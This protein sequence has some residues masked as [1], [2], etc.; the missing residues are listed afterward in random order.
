MLESILRSTESQRLGRYALTPAGDNALLKDLCEDFKDAVQRVPIISTY[1]SKATKVHRNVFAKFARKSS[2]MKIITPETCAIK[3]Q[4]ERPVEESDGDHHDICKLVVNGRLYTSIRDSISRIIDSTTKILEQEESPTPPPG[5]EGMTLRSQ[6]SSAAANDSQRIPIVIDRVPSNQNSST[7]PDSGDAVAGST[8]QASYEVVEVDLPVSFDPVKRSP[9]LPCFSVTS[10]EQNTAFFGREAVLRQIDKFLRPKATR[11]PEDLV[12]EANLLSAPEATLKTFALCGIG[13][14]GKTRIALQYAHTRRSEFEAIFWVSA[15]NSNVLA[16]EFAQIA[17]ELGLLELSEAQDLPAACE[18]V[19][20][21]LCNPVRSYD[22]GAVA[23]REVP[24]LL[25]FDNVDELDVLS[26]FWPTAGVGS[27]LMT[28]RDRGAKSHT[29][30]ANNGIDL[31]PFSGTEAEGFM[32]LITPSQS[33]TGQDAYIAEVAS[34]LGGLPLLITQ[35]S[36]LMNRLFLS[37]KDFLQLCDE[38]GISQVDW[39]Q[40]DSS[41]AGLV[42]SIFQKLGLGGLPSASLSILQM[43][44]FL[45][46][47]RVPEDILKSGISIQSVAGF[48]RTMKDY[49]DARLKLMQSSLIE[50]QP[51]T[52]HKPE[53]I[54]LHR[55]IQDV[56]RDNLGPSERVEIFE[57]TVKAVS[58]VWPFGELVD[59]FSTDR[60]EKCAGIFPSVIRLKGWQ[61]QIHQISYCQDPDSCAALYNDAGWYWFERGFPEEA[62]EYFRMTEKV[63]KKYQE[64]NATQTDK[65]IY[66]L[67]RAN[68]NHATASMETNDPKDCLS[69]YERWLSESSESSPGLDD[70]AF[71][72]ELACIH[73]ELGVAY[74]MNEQFDT[75]IACFEKSIQSFQQL[76]NY[77]DTMLNWPEPN[78]GFMYWVQGRYE[79]AEDVLLEI[80]SIHEE[81][82]GPDDTT[83]FKTGKMLYALGNVYTDRGLKEPDDLKR[84]EWLD[85]GLSFHSRCLKQYRTTLG[86]NHHRVGDVLHRLAD[87]KIRSKHFKEAHTFIKQAMDIFASR[88]YYKNELA[89]TTYKKGQMLLAEG[90]IPAAEKEFEKA[91]KLR[92]SLRPKDVKEKEDL[93]ELDYNSLVIFWSR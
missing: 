68:L 53:A 89:R 23:D 77:E 5:L 19:K 18:V 46:P 54:S 70:I 83:S 35:M 58:A 92:K 7:L 43:V 93:S 66:L 65:M 40:G 67:R 12:G 52:D 44:S 57:A 24:W 56:A 51:A 16:T 25:I 26:N 1:E 13:G 72:Y 21:W 61:E 69:R 2:V 41:R 30:T 64:T 22:T 80:L 6:I 60:Y 20:G 71:G 15:D 45:D 85:L 84:G 32:K 27:I 34:K 82:Y 33:N 62:K 79:E 86:D 91:F 28:S 59:R 47:D 8:T 78:L 31:R 76:P 9:K 75:A 81:A 38:N 14:T 11:D 90:D 49:F 48:P 74:A 4:G 29:H 17:V 39:T 87:H 42:F 55:I 36:N 3:S 88:S 37:Y 63:Y 73:N 10:Q 50:L